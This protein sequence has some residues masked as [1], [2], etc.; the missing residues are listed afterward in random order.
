MAEIIGSTG[1]FTPPE[2]AIAIELAQERLQKG[3]ASGYFFLFAEDG[4]GR[5]LGYACYGPVPATQTSYELYWIAV[6]REHQRGGLGRELLDRVE[7]AMAAAGGV[8]VYVETSSRAL[9]RSTQSF[10][11][12]AGYRLVADFPDFYAPGDGKLVFVK[13]LGRC[14]S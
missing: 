11:A 14:D 7:G 8:D 12:R 10:Y 2:V 1:F 13:R 9:Y 3:S 4:D 5:A 6:H